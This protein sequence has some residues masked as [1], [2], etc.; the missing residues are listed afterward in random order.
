MAHGGGG[1]LTQRLLD[2]IIRP[3]FDND[4]LLQRHDS[5]VLP[6]SRRCAFT[7][8]SY[9]IHPLVFP[10]GDIGKLAVCGTLNDLAMVGAK[11][12]YLSVGFILEEGLPLGTLRQIVD[13]MAATAHQAGV[14]IVTGDTKVVEKGKGDG[15]YI[16]TS[17]IGHIETAL[18]L[19]PSS[20]RP[21]DVII[22]NGDVGRHG[23]AVMASRENL[24]FETTLESD[25]ADLS[26]LVGELLEA[27]FPVHCMRDLTRGG[28]AT[29]LI[30]LARE[31]HHGLLLEEAS[32]SVSPAVRG[33]C[34]MLGLDPL[35][36]ANEGR[37]VTY[38]PEAFADDCLLLM[39]S[40]PLGR[41]ARV[42]GRVVDTHSSCV[43]LQTGLGTTRR[44]I[45]PS[46]EQLP[47]IC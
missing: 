16:N 6:V 12:A 21:G 5:A 37:F 45:L 36:V 27:G 29:A 17:G 33:A 15:I 25:C 11:P 32:V 47:R 31:S 46:G 26:G 13:S 41:N 40:H 28:L 30:E 19:H 38:L 1:M 35:F 7:T 39:Q 14:M 8:D 2:E 3:P 23:V 10:G 34:G 22:L 18:V 20:I 4:L 44:L 9:V 43:I 24:E 42:I